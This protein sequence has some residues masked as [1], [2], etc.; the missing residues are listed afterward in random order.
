MNAWAER[1]LPFEPEDGE[2]AG[3]RPA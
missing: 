2:V 1:G 3:P